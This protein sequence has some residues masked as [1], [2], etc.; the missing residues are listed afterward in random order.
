MA[1]REAACRAMGLPAGAFT[2]SYRDN[3]EFLLRHFATHDPTCVG[4][5]KLMASNS[6]DPKVQ[7]CNSTYYCSGPS[8]LGGV[9]KPEKE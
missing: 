5:T 6:T 9:A 7:R 4:V 8:W 1:Q 2:Q 3:Q